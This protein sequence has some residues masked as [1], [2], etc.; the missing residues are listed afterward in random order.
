MSET[1]SHSALIEG[2]A[3]GLTPVDTPFEYVLTTFVPMLKAAGVSDA[4]IN[5]ILVDNPREVLTVRAAKG[6]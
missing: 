6:A 5:R 1:D 2:L 3:A 4:D